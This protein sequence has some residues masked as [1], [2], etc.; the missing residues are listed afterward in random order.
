MGKRQFGYLNP[1]FGNLGVTHVTLVDGSLESPWSFALFELFRYLL[2]FRSY[3]AHVYSSA[4]FTG[5]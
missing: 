4:V 1:I 2:R 5:G 3:E